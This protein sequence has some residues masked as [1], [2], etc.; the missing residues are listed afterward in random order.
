MYEEA[1]NICKVN[2]VQL[3]FEQVQTMKKKQFPQKLKI[4][5]YL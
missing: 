3:P 2:N 1:L 4:I 5:F